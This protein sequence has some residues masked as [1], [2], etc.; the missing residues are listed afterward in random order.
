MQNPV[1]ECEDCMNRRISEHMRWNAYMRIRGY[2]HGKKR[3]DRGM[4]HPELRPFANISYL[5]RFK[6]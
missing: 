5:E 4:V 3:N 2:R 1:C 6:D